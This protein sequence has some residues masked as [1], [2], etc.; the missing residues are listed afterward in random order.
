MLAGMGAGLLLG[1]LFAGFPKLKEIYL[2]K[3]YIYGMM[4]VAF[5]WIL[6]SNFENNIKIAVVLY[7]LG[8]FVV[9][10][11]NVYAQTMVQIIVPSEK[12]GSAMGAM[13]CISTFMAPI[14]A[15][16]GGYLG[17]YLSSSMA[18]FIGSF[19]I[20]IVAIFWSLNKNIR[21][22]PSVNKFHNIT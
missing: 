20:L 19:I 9:G 22:L 15:L 21:N 17:E 3:L 16:F 18:V 2:G 8:W 4:I 1:S 6:F 5:A 11:V 14:G 13:V 12:I 7:G 10:L